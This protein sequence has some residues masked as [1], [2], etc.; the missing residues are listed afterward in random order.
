[1]RCRSRFGSFS[2]GIVPT[3]LLILVDYIVLYAPIKL[4]DPVQLKNRFFVARKYQSI[5]G[6]L[7]GSASAFICE[8]VVFRR[9]GDRCYLPGG[10]GREHPPSGIAPKWVP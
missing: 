10:F 2:F 4:S 1:V 7:L 3:F 5:T 9:R 8:T 6:P